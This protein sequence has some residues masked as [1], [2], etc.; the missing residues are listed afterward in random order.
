MLWSVLLLAWLPVL[1]LSSAVYEHSLD[2]TRFTKAGEIV[3]PEGLKADTTEEYQ[4][5]REPITDSQL[6]ALQKL[7][8]Q[9][10]LYAVQVSLPDQQPVRA[11]LPAACIANHLFQ[12]NISLHLD[13]TGHIV[14]LQVSTPTGRCDKDA[15]LQKLSE[16][17]RQLLS[18]PPD[19]AVPVKSPGPAP[20]VPQGPPG[21]HEQPLLGVQQGQQQPQQQLTQSQQQGGAAG[22]GERP[23]PP[24]DNRTWLQKNWLFVMAGGVMVLNLVLKTTVGD[25]AQQAGAGAATGAAPAAAA[26]AG[27]GG[28][29]GGARRPRQGGR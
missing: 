15:A 8:E 6:A 24:P 27:G 14:G 22:D 23:P 25:P 28:G 26:V 5:R 21:V 19:A 1:C 29:G 4:L 11:S 2:G 12:E 13:R 9:D 20:A 16:V 18:Q 10:G 17:P 7:V 3:G